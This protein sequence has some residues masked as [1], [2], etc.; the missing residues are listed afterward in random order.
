[1]NNGRL[2]EKHQAISQGSGTSGPLMKKKR[3]SYRPTNFGDDGTVTQG[4]RP[5][6]KRHT[7]SLCLGPSLASWTRK[8]SLVSQLTSWRLACNEQLFNAKEPINPC[9]I[10]SS[11]P[12]PYYCLTHSFQQEQPCLL[13]LYRSM[14]DHHEHSSPGCPVLGLPSSNH[15]PLQDCELHE[16]IL[17]LQ[18][19]FSKY[20]FYGRGK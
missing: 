8:P 6:E 2:L 20:F 19:Y 1:M 12:Q 13:L 10:F 14:R 17:H 11:T 5:S 9:P 16:Y 3:R 7:M 4:S 15:L 18:E